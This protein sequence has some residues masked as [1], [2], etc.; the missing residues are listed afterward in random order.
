MT[1]LQELKDA[2]DKAPEDQTVVDKFLIR[3]AARKR[4]ALGPCDVFPIC[5]NCAALGITEDT[6]AD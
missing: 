2:I 3:E 4:A 6:H 1:D 5:S